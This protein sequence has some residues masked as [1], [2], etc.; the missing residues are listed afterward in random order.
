MYDGPVEE[1]PGEQQV[2]PPADGKSPVK[3]ALTV[4]LAE[5]VGVLKLYE[6]ASGV[7]LKS[8]WILII[9]G[10]RGA[11]AAEVVVV[12]VGGVNTE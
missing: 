6:T 4:E 9:V 7:R 12:D 8:V 5:V 2:A 11:S 3:F 10:V 1:R